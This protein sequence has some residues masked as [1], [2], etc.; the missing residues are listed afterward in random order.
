M[1]LIG[2]SF[3]PMYSSAAS[4]PSCAAL[5]TD[6]TYGLAGGDPN[7]IPG[8]LTTTIVAAAPANPNS[9]P[10]P[11]PATPAYCQ[12]NFTYTTGLSGPANGYDV[13][14][15]P[16]IKIQVILPLN[17]VDGGTGGTVNGGW[18][19]KIM[20]TGSAGAS[21]SLG[22]TTYDE[23]RNFSQAGYPIRLGMTGA[24]SDNGNISQYNPPI[25]NSGPQAG[26]LAT[27][28]LADWSYRGTHYAKEWAVSISTT[29]F[30]SAPT[31]VY[32]NGCSG[33][34][35]M[36][37]GQ[38]MNYGNEYDGFVIGA[39]AYY[40]QQFRLADTWPQLVFKKLV[41][42]G[43]TL[44]TSAQFTAVTNAAT[45]ACDVLGPDTVADGIVDDPRACT[46]SA[47]ANICGAATAP[48]APNCLTAQQAA[49]IDRIW[50]GP[51]NRFGKRIHYPYDRGI[52]LN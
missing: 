27:G 15:M 18:N 43:G 4:L 25:I 49:A 31:R 44:P 37:M 5:A 34:G 12:V 47:K 29:Y 28:E 17:T 36:G 52:A 22:G 38:L 30:G 33:G 21:T 14:V 7:I 26:Q 24:I 16:K 19:G 45:A 9:T 41:Q 6:P 10:D 13:G 51:R 42:Q 50:D 32:Y 3:V 11:T 39:P 8:T 48:A 20:V 2:S 35:N 40:W 46:F 23:G 1:V